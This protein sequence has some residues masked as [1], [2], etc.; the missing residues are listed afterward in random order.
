MRWGRTINIHQREYSSWESL[1]SEHLYPQF[2][3]T[4]IHKNFTKLKIHW[5]QH[6]TSGRYQHPTHTNEQFFE[7]ESKHRYIENNRGYEP[8]LFNRY[9]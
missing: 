5:T 7:T 4:N 3:G 8:S 9:Q 6:N 2:K 1:N